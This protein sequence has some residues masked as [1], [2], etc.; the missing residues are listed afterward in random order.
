MSESL[1]IIYAGTPDFAVPAL[2][3]LCDSQHQVVAVY[4]QPDRRAGRGRKLAAS[5]VKTTALAHDIPVQQPQSLKDA[6]ALEMLR[7]YQADVMVVAAYGLILPAGALHAPTHGCLNI[8]ASLLPR[9]RGAAPIQRAIEAGDDSSGVTIMQMDVGLDT[10][11]MLHKV[12]CPID[13]H[14]TAAALHDTLAEVGATALMDTLQVLVAG[15]LQPQPQDESQVTYAHKLEKKEAIIDWHD[16]TQAIHRRI[17]AFN[18]WPVAQTTVAGETLRIWQSIALESSAGQVAAGSV[19]ATDD[20]LDV[21]TADGVLRLLQVQPP[22]KKPMA[23][24]DY[25]RSRDLAVG[26]QL[27]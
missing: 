17:C 12:S 15:Q 3:A 7:S 27:G 20:G 21:A 9:W 18:P 22:G 2:R 25:L 13:Q 5:P 23:A 6:G 11:D 24:A 19:V 10:G 14:T 8:H 4:T 1:R 16:T 26:T